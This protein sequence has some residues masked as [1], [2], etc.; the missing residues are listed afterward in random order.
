MKIAECCV[1]HGAELTEGVGQLR[2]QY[3]KFEQDMTQQQQEGAK[4][5]F[6]VFELCIIC[7]MISAL[8]MCIVVEMDYVV[9]CSCFYCAAPK[10][11]QYTT[12]ANNAQK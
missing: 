10:E 11:I 2:G 7:S 8:A 3:D 4:E 6:F 5:W 1:G 9:C 12:N